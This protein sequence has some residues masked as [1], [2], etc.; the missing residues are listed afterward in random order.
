[1]KTQKTIKVPVVPKEK[2]LEAKLKEANDRHAKCYESLKGLENSISIY[3]ETIDRLQ[4]EIAL[5]SKKNNEQSSIIATQKEELDKRQELHLSTMLEL[6][7]L[8]CKWYVRL[9]GKS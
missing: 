2:V 1:M 4:S 9:F 8:R 7:K 5:I 3:S 6:S